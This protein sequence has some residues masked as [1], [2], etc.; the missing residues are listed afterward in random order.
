MEIQFKNYTE[1]TKEESIQLLNIRNLETVRNNSRTTDI[2][3]IEDH[4]KWIVRLQE[5]NDNV[6]YAVVVDLEIVGG[7]NLIDVNSEKKFAYWGLFFKDDIKPL[8]SSLVT[9]LFLN[10]VFTYFKIEELKSEVMKLNINAYRFSLNFELKVYNEA[11][12]EDKEYY[13]MRICRRDWNDN[14]DKSFFKMMKRRTDKIKF[15][16]WEKE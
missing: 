16:V 11:I 4:L 8:I 5:Q 12:Y 14:Q 10:R 2:I 13:L 9:Y 15:N 6:Y 1:L 7:I 3:E